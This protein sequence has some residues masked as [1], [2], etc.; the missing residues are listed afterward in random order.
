MPREEEG[1]QAIDREDTKLNTLDVRA[2]DS[3]LIIGQT[4]IP[5]GSYKGIDLLLNLVTLNK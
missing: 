5:P 3:A 1:L 2:R 4:Y